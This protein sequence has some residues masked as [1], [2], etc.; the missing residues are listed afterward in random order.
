MNEVLETTIMLEPF[1]LCLNLSLEHT[2]I[3]KGAENLRPPS[4][5]PWTTVKTNPRLGPYSSA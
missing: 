2:S 5:S 3:H 1:I 4:F